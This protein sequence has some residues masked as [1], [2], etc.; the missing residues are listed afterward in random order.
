[1]EAPEAEPLPK[2]S[3]PIAPLAYMLAEQ[4]LRLSAMV[5]RV[6]IVADQIEI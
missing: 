5:C 2:T 4:N 1:M 6:A 3:G